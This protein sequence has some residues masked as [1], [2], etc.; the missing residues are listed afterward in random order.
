MVTPNFHP[1]FCGVGDFSVRLG[2][3]LARRGHEVAFFSRSP[4][5]PHPEAP[6]LAAHGIGGRFSTGI[7]R[8]VGDAIEAFGATDVVIQYTAQMWDVWRFGSPAQVQLARRARRAGARVT[9][10]AHELYIP[11]GPRPDLIA[12]ASLQRLQFAAVM[13][14]CDRIFVTTE[15]R[16]DEIRETCRVLGLPRPEV[17]RIGANALPAPRRRPP[18]DP[19][20]PR[21]GVFSTAGAGKRFD[22]LL[23]AFEEIARAVPGAELVLIGALGAPEQPLVRKVL[24]ELERHPARARIRLTGALPLAAVADEIADLDVYLH[25]METGANTRSSTLPTAFGAG[26][27]V[28]AVRGAETDASIF[29]DGENLLYAREMSG[30]AYAVAALRLLGD[31]ALAG[32]LAEGARR[33]YAQHLAWDRVA[34]HF[35]AEA[36]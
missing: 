25:P 22:V 20:A 7:A 21:L 31:P 1:R 29:H 3:E 18:A 19:R 13:A 6:G 35:L 5:Q 28:V 14:H 17:L 12:G 15:T 34:D 36:A 4:A 32:R 26:I 27:P 9:L 10:V 30:P 8:G 23:G 16:A 33:L 2:I 11:Y 24:G